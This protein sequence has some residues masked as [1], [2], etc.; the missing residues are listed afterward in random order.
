MGKEKRNKFG[1]TR[2]EKALRYAAKGVVAKCALVDKWRAEQ[3]AQA[4][5]QQQ[6][7]DGPRRVMMNGQMYLVDNNGCQP[8]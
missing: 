7:V 5:Q 4:E 1:E 2:E 8:A 6:Q 3:A